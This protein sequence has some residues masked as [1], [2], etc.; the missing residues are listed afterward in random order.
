MSPSAPPPAFVRCTSREDQPSIL[1]IFMDQ[2]EVHCYH[3]LLN[4]IFRLLHCPECARPNKQ[5]PEMIH[6]CNHKRLKY[7][8]LWSVGEGNRC[9]S[10]QIRLRHGICMKATFQLIPDRPRKVF[11]FP[12]RTRSEL[13]SMQFSNHKVQLTRKFIII[14]PLGKTINKAKAFSDDHEHVNFLNYNFADENP[15]KTYP[16]DV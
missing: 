10:S 1:S 15:L 4:A 13:N 11:L 14:N 8:L 12:Q 9:I 7:L 2:A 16:G 3:Y 6:N 5:V